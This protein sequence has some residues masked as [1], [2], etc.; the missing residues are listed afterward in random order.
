MHCN[1]HQLSMLVTRETLGYHLKMG[2][3]FFLPMSW[4]DNICLICEAYVVCCF[5]QSSNLVSV[6]RCGGQGR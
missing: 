1:G 3:P 4:F 6:E 5:S 2:Q